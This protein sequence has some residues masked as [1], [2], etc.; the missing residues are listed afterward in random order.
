MLIHI[1]SG[2]LKPDFEVRHAGMQAQV[3]TLGAVLVQPYITLL[4]RDQLGYT[5]CGKQQSQHKT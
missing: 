5:K 1:A 3:I 4:N 2:F